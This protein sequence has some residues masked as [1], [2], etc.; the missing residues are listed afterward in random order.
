MMKAAMNEV[1]TE[2]A[3]AGTKLFPCVAGAI[4]YQ[5]YMFGNFPQSI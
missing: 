2:A 1:V 3:K 4:C 5:N